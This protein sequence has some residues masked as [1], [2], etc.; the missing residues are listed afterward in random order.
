M[1]ITIKS[2][3]KPTFRNYSLQSKYNVDQALKSAFTIKR[4]I[5]N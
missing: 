4:T 5:R 2:I 3:K 1:L